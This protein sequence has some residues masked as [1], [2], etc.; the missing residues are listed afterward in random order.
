MNPQNNIFNKGDLVTFYKHNAQYAPISM[1]LGCLPLSRGIVIS[2]YTDL[3]EQELVDVFVDD[4][5]ITFHRRH[6]YAA[7]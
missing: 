2:C 7:N 1:L 5:I 3:Y 6:I 4:Q